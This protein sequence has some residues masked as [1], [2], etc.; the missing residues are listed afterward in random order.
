[1]K[2]TIKTDM[3]KFKSGLIRARGMAKGVSV[4]AM[5]EAMEKFHHDVLYEPPKVPRDTNLLAD[6]HTIEVTKTSDGSKGVLK[7][8]TPYA[9]S[10][11]EG[12]SRHGTPYKFKAPGSGA[13]WIQSK[14]LRYK[15]SYLKMMANKIKQIVRRWFKWVS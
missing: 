10:L 3:R 14:V 8:D 15:R 5:E 2:S 11:H 6:K 12:I 7:A 9:A 13:K 4:E 1:M